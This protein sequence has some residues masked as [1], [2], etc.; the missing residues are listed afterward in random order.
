M[1]SNN[2]DCHPRRKKIRITMK[3][4]LLSSRLL[5][6]LSL[7]FPLKS[8]DPPCTLSDQTLQWTLARYTLSLPMASLSRMCTWLSGTSP[9]QEGT[10]SVSREGTWFTLWTLTPLLNGGR[11]RHWTRMLLPRQ[12]HMASSLPA[13]SW[14]PL[15]WFEPP[16]THTHSLYNHC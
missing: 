5:L 9:A 8:Q 14:V 6:P 15:R 3:M 1:C 16:P 11:G 7:L 4:Q 2:I 12:E 13:T 10:N